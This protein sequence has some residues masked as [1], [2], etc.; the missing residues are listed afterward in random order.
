MGSYFVMFY[1]HHSHCSFLFS[2]YFRE[3]QKKNNIHYNG[4]SFITVMLSEPFTLILDMSLS[5]G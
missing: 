5:T 3:N 2:F 1:I 4:T